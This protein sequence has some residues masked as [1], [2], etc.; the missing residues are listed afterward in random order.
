[1]GKYTNLKKIFSKLTFSLILRAGSPS[2]NIKYGSL[3]ELIR[4]LRCLNVTFVS[5]VGIVFSWFIASSISASSI[6]L[7]CSFAAFSIRLIVGSM[8]GSVF[9]LSLLNMFDVLDVIQEGIDCRYLVLRGMCA[10]TICQ[11]S[12]SFQRT[13]DL[14]RY[15]FWNE[16]NLF[17]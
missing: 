7:L 11:E 6:T 14:C 2:L 12:Q 10:S 15:S 3:S 1:M 9:F 5:R 4:L 17:K 13:S 8:G 16:F